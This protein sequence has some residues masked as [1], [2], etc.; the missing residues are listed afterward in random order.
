MRD[1]LTSRFIGMK[2]VLGYGQPLAEIFFP[3]NGD[4]LSSDDVLILVLVSNA[5]RQRVKRKRV[6]LFSAGFADHRGKSSYNQQ[7][8]L[9][10]AQVV[11]RKLSQLLNDLPNV[12]S[13][14][15]ISLGESQAHQNSKDS[16]ELA[17]DRRVVVYDAVPEFV[18]FAE[19]KNYESEH[20]SRPTFLKFE[21]S[22]AHSQTNTNIPG[23]RP[24]HDSIADLMILGAKKIWGDA[25]DEFGSLKEIKFQSMDAGLRVADVRIEVSTELKVGYPN[26]T[27]K[28]ETR[29]W[30]TWNKPTP[31]VVVRKSVHAR[32]SGIRRHE[33]QV[34]TRH[35]AD[36]N[37]FT[38]PPPKESGTGAA[39]SLFTSPAY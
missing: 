26:I 15:S 31:L 11:S 32:S 34:L 9:R 22:S 2:K 39:D 38:F 17:G 30:Y 20:V 37:A 28:S 7:L 36:R 29:I 13:V 3:T 1:Q 23:H 4:N 24:G 8:G 5:V 33:R 12:S 21:D 16:A 6:E 14:S 25:Y 18:P 35:E 10:R 19:A 27:V